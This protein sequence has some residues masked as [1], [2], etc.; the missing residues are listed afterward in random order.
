[1]NKELERYLIV[2]LVLILIGLSGCVQSNVDTKVDTKLPDIAVK[3]QKQSTPTI[4]HME[5][6]ANALVCMF[7]PET[8]EARKQEQE[9]NR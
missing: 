7:A 8:C 4:A 6:I 3:E 1:M 2:F 9:M 5:G